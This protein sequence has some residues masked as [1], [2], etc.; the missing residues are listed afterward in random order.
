MKKTLPGKRFIICIT[1]AA[2]V[3]LLLSGLVDPYRSDADPGIMRWDTVST[4]NSVPN[5]NDVLNPYI[6]NSFTGSEIRD[7]AVADDGKTLLAAVTV[8]NRT[9]AAANNPGPLGV[10]YNTANS[11]IS[12]NTAA[13]RVLA[14]NAAWSADKHVYHVA[15]APDD[16]KIWAVTAGTQATGPVELWVTTNGGAEWHN[17]GVPA[18]AAAGEA[19]GAIDISMDYGTG[20]DYAVGT[21]SGAG[22]GRLFIMK[23]AGFGSWVQQQAPEANIDYF[24]MKFS[25]TYNGDNSVVMIYAD[26]NATNYNVG[27]RD[28][29]S[30]SML[31]Y[32]FPGA[33]VE[34]S[35]T[36]NA[37]PSY[38]NL[39]VA[40]L[41]LPSDYSGM[42]PALRRAFV[43]LYAPFPD[44]ANATGV[45]RID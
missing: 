30:N 1:L 25:P 3:T 24:A 45:F 19:I 42:S 33:G 22:N 21:R 8:D 32:V 5:R 35:T 28:M 14:G 23:G 6:N 15:V 11:G 7:L 36:A 13:Y 26:V 10:L 20:R 9:I 44:A 43:S 17:A 16:A 39:A 41:S 18:M 27:L 4:P 12:W 40:D 29:S 2:V 37:S 34:V 31:S 38:D